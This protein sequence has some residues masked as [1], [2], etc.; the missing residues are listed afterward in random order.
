MINENIKN[1]PNILDEYPILEIEYN[2][3]GTKKSFYTLASEKDIKETQIKSDENELEFNYNQEKISKEEFDREM[4]KLKVK[5]EDQNKVYDTLIFDLIKNEDLESLK[6]EIISAKLNNIE[7]KRLAT[8]LS[9]I[10]DNKIEEFQQNN[11]EFKMTNITEWN[12]RYDIIA[13]NISKSREL[14]GFILSLME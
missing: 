3:D 10:A 2:R 12:R 6:H 14:E 5:L 11:K 4:L 1:N 8:S 7:L 9:S 13:K